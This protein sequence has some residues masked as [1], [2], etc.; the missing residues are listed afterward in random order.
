MDAHN[1]FYNFAD[2]IREVTQGDVTMAFIDKEAGKSPEFRKL[3]ESFQAYQFS[4][5]QFGTE[6]LA[7]PTRPAIPV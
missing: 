3:F 2:D 6:Q 5:P 1:W 7:K 4:G